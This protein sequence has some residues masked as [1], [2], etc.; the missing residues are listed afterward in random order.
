MCELGGR[1]GVKTPKQ[2]SYVAKDPR[3]I[4]DFWHV[5]AY[6]FVSDTLFFL[7]LLNMCVAVCCSVLQCVAVCLAV[8]WS[9]LQFFCDTCM[10]ISF[11]HSHTLVLSLVLMSYIYATFSQAIVGCCSVLQCVA[12][13]YRVLLFFLRRDA[14]RCSTPQ[15]SCL[16]ATCSQASKECCSALQRA[17]VCCSVLQCVAVRCRASQMSCIYATCLQAIMGCCSVL[18]S[19]AVCCSVLQC[20]AVRCRCHVHTR[21]SHR[22]A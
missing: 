16:Y 1:C 21:P 15:M 5:H 4:R 8:L 14:A 13:R 19:A 22:P 20:V 11:T 18:Q 6:R 9:V 12:V 2:A 7:F 3:D 10:C 17:A